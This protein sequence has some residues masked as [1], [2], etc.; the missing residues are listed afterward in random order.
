MLLTVSE[1]VHGNINSRVNFFDKILMDTN[2]GWSKAD[3]EKL[4]LESNKLFDE[5]GIIKPGFAKLATERFN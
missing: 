1:T 4:E 2:G 3:F 5:E